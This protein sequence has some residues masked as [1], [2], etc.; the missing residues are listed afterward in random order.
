MLPKPNLT[1]VEVIRNW[2][3]RLELIEREL[4]DLVLHIRLFKRVAEI[5]ERNSKINKPNH[6]YRFL[7]WAFNQ[8]TAMS[9]RRLMGT[10]PDERLLG[11]LLYD[12]KANCHLIS[13]KRFLAIWS[14]DPES[15][16]RAFSDLCG[17]GVDCLQKCLV[18]KDIERIGQV[19]KEI[20]RYATQWVAH[21]LGSKKNSCGRLVRPETVGLNLANFEDAASVLVEVFNRYNQL[22][23]G[24][25][26]AFESMV[27]TYKWDD[28]FKTPWIE[29][30]TA[31][32]NARHGD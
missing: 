6:F 27:F 17:D 13:R 11:K 24:P 14:N 15:A 20:N 25:K 12:I 29:A 22:L 5:V 18:Q 19:C 21:D 2:K 7:D 32:R 26:V 31:G 16:T 3:G 9:I 4:D 10:K 30:K 8:A 1:N 28:I 23:G